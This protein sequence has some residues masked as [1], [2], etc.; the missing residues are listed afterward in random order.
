MD[1]LDIE[2]RS[3][4]ARQDAWCHICGEY[5]YDDWRCECCQECEQ[6]HYACECG[7]EEEDEHLGI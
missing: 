7:S 2:L 5:S 4:Q 1:H 6:T 3:Y